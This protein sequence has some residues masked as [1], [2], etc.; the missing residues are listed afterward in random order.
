M[1]YKCPHCKKMVAKSHFSC[2]RGE[3]AAGKKKKFS[4]AELKIRTERLLKNKFNP[5][6]QKRK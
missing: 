5:T 6:D 1:K 2:G 3:M 4:K